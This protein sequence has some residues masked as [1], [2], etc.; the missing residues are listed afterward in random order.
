MFDNNR[1]PHN[2]GNA[3]YMSAA[4]LLDLLKENADITHID[5][6]GVWTRE[7]FFYTELL[8]VLEERHI[9]LIKF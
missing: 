2:Y 1:I 4:T 3:D 6:S 5:F 8:D 9:F 7:A